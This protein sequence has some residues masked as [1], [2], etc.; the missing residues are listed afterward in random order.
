MASDIKIVIYGKHA[1]GKSSLV[2]RYKKDVFVGTGEST[3]GAAFCTANLIQNGK[4][5]KAQIWDTAGMEKFK[6]IVPMYLRGANIV[7]FCFDIPRLEVIQE[8]IRFIRNTTMEAKIVLVQTKIDN[9]VSNVINE[10]L[11]RQL[12]IF[13]NRENYKIFYTSAKTGHSVREL[14]E[15]CIITGHS[16]KNPEEEPGKIEISDTID[17]IDATGKYGC[18]IIV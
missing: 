8:G 16:M 2:E 14:F 1:I 18:C 6:S 3:I 9:Y 17:S 5:I 13:L 10:E 12:E 11:S 7:I 15:Y 4:T